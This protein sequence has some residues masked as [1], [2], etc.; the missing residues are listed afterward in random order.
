MHSTT[1]NHNQHNTWASNVQSIR[2]TLND[3]SSSN[4]DSSAS[5]RYDPTG[6]GI[7]STQQLN[8]DW[9]KFAN[10]TFFSSAVVNVNVAFDRII[11][12]Y[13]FDGTKREIE[14]FF[15]SLTG[16]EKHVYDRFPKSIGYLFFSGS[17]VHEQN[18]SGTYVT[19]N[20]YIGSLY[21]TLSKNITGFSVLD[22]SGSSLSVEMQIYAPAIANNNQVV[23]Q[24]LSGTTHG[25]T[26]LL[27]QSTSTSACALMLIVTSGS[28]QLNASA[29]ITKGRFNHVVT[30]YDRDDNKLRIYIDEALAITTTSSVAMSSI[31]FKLSPL[32]IGSGVAHSVGSMTVTPMQTF[33]GALDELRIYHAKRGLDDQRNF[34]RKAVYA[35]QALKLYM[36]FNEPTGTIGVNSTA[37]DSSGHSLHGT[38]SNFT[39]ALRSTGS[40]A[41]PMLYERLDL[42]PVLFP[43][44]SSVVNLNIDLLTSASEYDNVNP[45]IITRLVPQHYFIE[46]QAF[47]GLD[48]EI[49]SIVNVITGTSI[50]GSM[51]VGQAQTMAAFLYVWAKFFDD[52]KCYIDSFSTIEH[53]DYNS[54][55][56]VPD[57]FIM[58]YARRHGLDAPALFMSSDIAQFIDAENIDDVNINTNDVSLRYVQNNIWRR[59]FSNINEIMRSKGT[60]HSIKSFI[61]AV[62]INPDTTLRMHEY[63]GQSHGKLMNLRQQRAEISTMLSMT[64]SNSLLTSSYLSGTRREIGFPNPRGTF[65]QT[66]QF[67][68][69]GVSNDV[70]DGLFT[71]GSWSIEAMCDFP[72]GS[73]LYTTQSIIRLCTT[74]TLA[75][76]GTI[77]NIVAMSGS[78]GSGS[79]KA[80]VR[81]SL[82]SST[83]MTLEMA[84]TGVNIF[85]GNRWNVSVGRVRNDEINSIVSSSYFI[86]LARQSYG[87]IALTMMTQSYFHEDRANSTS[88]N[89]MQAVTSSYNV[90]GAFLAIGSQSM[91]PVFLGDATNVTNNEARASLFAGNIGHIRFWSR[92]VTVDEWRE[93]VTNFKSLGVSSSLVNF[94]FVTALTGAFGR[95][96]LDASTDQ[97]VT[98][99]DASGMITIIDQSQNDRHMVGTGFESSV[100]IVH[101]VMFNYSILSTRIDEGSTRSKIRIRSALD[102]ERVGFDDAVIAPLHELSANEMSIDDPRF[103]IDFSIIDALN[104]DIVRILSSL[105]A[106]DDALGEH[107][108]LYADDYPTLERLRDLYFNRLTDSINLKGMFEFFKWFDSS[109]GNFIQLLLPS[110]VRFLGINYVIES[111][112]LERH[113]VR[114]V[115]PGMYFNDAARASALGKRDKN[116]DILGVV[117][118][119]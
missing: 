5:F 28:A 87:D 3:I 73:R 64:A 11:N 49:G 110:K 103:S 90:S 117:T 116:I 83:A 96:R 79:V 8:V 104:E 56:T 77:M 61:R 16:F 85:D 35:D 98:E 112:M 40:I 15:D 113:K 84:L 107:N 102:P 99:S 93:H 71:S 65:V 23:L 74:G 105:D 1:S 69:H 48:N 60:L 37:L 94:N 26:L 52:I 25:I 44:H 18:H 7:R 34:G 66:A 55:D 72:S 14:L 108:L 19:V 42:S 38:I 45:N 86:R 70:S 17:T 118:K 67:M 68:P 20:D 47:D 111:H 39:H 22:P 92:A 24:K 31:D 62:G 46:G 43:A 106:F 53:I 78:D 97:H 33:S 76:P 2:R 29:S 6:D 9:S 57:Q 30:T 80:F 21:P 63:G 88:A 95:L 81:T 12:G 27:S 54:Y 59:I 91:S 51:Q 36:K 89:V 10:H 75:T 109:M 100:R 58:A 13:P 115:L 4:I 50:P 41:T 32:L 101:P 114:Y 119:F 82:S